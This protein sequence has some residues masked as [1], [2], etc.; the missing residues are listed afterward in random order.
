MMP[1]VVWIWPKCNWEVTERGGADAD[2]SQQIRSYYPK[3][4]KDVLAPK[5]VPCPVE[6]AG[7]DIQ[8]PLCCWGSGY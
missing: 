5:N 1:L 4:A 3:I 8:S 2:G 6:G 7:F